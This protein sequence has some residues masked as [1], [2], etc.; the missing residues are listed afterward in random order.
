LQYGQ[1][2]GPN[3]GHTYHICLAQHYWLTGD[4]V[5]RE[6]FLEVANWAADSPW[7]KKRMM[8]DKRGYGNFMITF[9]YAYQ[10]TGDKKYYDRAMTLSGWIDKPFS[11]LGGTLYAKGAARFLQMKIDNGEI[12][13]DYRKVRDLLMTFGDLY[14]TLPASRWTRWLEQR[15]FHAETLCLCYLYAPKDHPG[16]EK[17]YAKGAQIIDEALN[18]FPGRYVATK[19]W[20]MC[21]SNTGAYLRAKLVKAAENAK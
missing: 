18:R 3:A 1:G 19:S 11:G 21:F 4:R 8:G 6:A 13:D 5:S 10:L 7:F 9:A 15:C 16:R 14:L 2:G 17:Y 20:M 12:D